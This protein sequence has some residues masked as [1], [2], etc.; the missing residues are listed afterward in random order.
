MSSPNNF[1]RDLLYVG[2]G[3][4]QVGL[5]TTGTELNPLFASDGIVN[6]KVASFYLQNT[7]TFNNRERGRCVWLQSFDNSDIPQVIRV[8][9]YAFA[10]AGNVS[11]WIAQSTSNSINVSS[12]SVTGAV[13][14]KRFSARGFLEID[15]AVAYTALLASRPIA[16]GVSIFGHSGSFS[17]VSQVSAQHLAYKP[18]KYESSV[19]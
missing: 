2:T 8:K 17:L 7:L 10:T 1:D 14:L 5:S 9:G 15:E 13:C 16:I 4:R 11:F 3:A 19:R 12:Q 6:E 18:P